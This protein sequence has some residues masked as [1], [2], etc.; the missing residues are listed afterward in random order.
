MKKFSM[1]PKKVSK[2]KHK[3]I[4]KLDKY[5]KTMIMKQVFML[6]KGERLIENNV[7]EQIFPPQD[8]ED[9]YKHLTI[10][11]D[12][13][14]VFELLAGYRKPDFLNLSQFQKLA[15]FPGLT[16]E[17]LSKPEY[18]ILFKNFATRINKTLM[19]LDNF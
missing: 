8:N 12:A 18:G 7:F 13:R 1:I 14:I 5:L 11:N 9:D 16:N 6:I 2:N 10:Y 17:S 3:E 15:S 4:S 19:T